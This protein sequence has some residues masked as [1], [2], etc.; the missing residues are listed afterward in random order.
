[1]VCFRANQSGDSWLGDHT[2]KVGH[3]RQEV[4]HRHLGRLH[5]LGGGVTRKVKRRDRNVVLE[6]VVAEIGFQPLQCLLRK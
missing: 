4:Q 6:S 3:L 5:Q 2:G 1:M